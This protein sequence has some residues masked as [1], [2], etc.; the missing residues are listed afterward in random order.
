MGKIIRPRDTDIVKQSNDVT[1]YRG[2]LTL[3]QE[4]L[5]TLF[6]S[7]IAKSQTEFPKLTFSVTEICHALNTRPED[8]RPALKRMQERML[9]I[10][11]I[12]DMESDW[13]SYAPISVVRHSKD[14]KTVE[15]TLNPELKPFFLELSEQYT[16]IEAEKTYR[17]HS[18]YSIRIYRYICQWKSRIEDVHPEPFPLVLDYQELREE[19]KLGDKWKKTADFRI[20]VLE[21]AIKDIT[22][23]RIGYHVEL[24]KPNKVGRNIFDFVLLVS[25]AKE[26]KPKKVTAAKKP[27]KAESTAEEKRN[28]LYKYLDEHPEEYQQLVKEYRAEQYL[29]G[30]PDISGMNP[31]QLNAYYMERAAKALQA[32]YGKV[33]K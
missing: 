30:M 25:L 1:H 24:G 23:A 31:A 7:K 13:E 26:E 2:S 17:L 16:I 4:K 18:A 27:T 8:M 6:Y 21:P 11:D 32:K 10:G 33:A 15:V 19:F 9:E 3:L 20:K 28:S 5:F 12:N 14:K 22:E 29:D